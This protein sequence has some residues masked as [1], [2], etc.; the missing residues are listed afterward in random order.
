MT[1]PYT[2]SQASGEEIIPIAEK[3]QSAI[4][5]ESYP[6]ATMALLYTIFVIAYP[7]IKDKDLQEGIKNA[8]QHICLL[9]DGY[10]NP[11]E[12]TKNYKVN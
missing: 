10:E 1:T 11:V 7:E 3:I 4:D 9:L 6:N 5:G 8:S 2:T 12:V